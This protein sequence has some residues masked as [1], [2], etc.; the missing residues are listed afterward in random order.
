MNKSQVIPL[1]DRL[2]NLT[3]QRVRKLMLNALTVSEK[4]VIDTAVDMPFAFAYH[5][6]F[7][8]LE[9]A[10]SLMQ[11]SQMQS[12]KAQYDLDMNKQ[13]LKY[14]KKLTQL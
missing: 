13:A 5:H 11:Y 3:L 14:F 7:H 12:I 9:E 4:K 6:H 1:V 2:N 8:D 10:Y